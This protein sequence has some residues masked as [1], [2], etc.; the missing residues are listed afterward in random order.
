MLMY[1][2]SLWAATA[3][4]MLAMAVTGAGVAN[5]QTPDKAV[6]GRVERLVKPLLESGSINALSLGFVDGDKTYVLNFGKISAN[7]PT[8]P[9]ADTVYEIGSITKVFTGTI[10]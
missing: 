6:T 10:L 4:A 7:Q 8:L 2:E 5:A 3:V 1:V 9:D